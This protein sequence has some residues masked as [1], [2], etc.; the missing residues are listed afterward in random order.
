MR[1]YIDEVQDYKFV[2]IY[3]SQMLC[4]LSGWYPGDK[5]FR[6]MR[7]SQLRAIIISYFRKQQKQTQTGG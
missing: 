5:S 4:L 2:P 6:K 7:N 3:R 1:V